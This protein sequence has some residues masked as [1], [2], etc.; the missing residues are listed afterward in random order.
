MFIMSLELQNN[1]DEVCKEMQNI[2]LTEYI[3]T[4]FMYI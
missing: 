3:L 1:F 2:S 4:E